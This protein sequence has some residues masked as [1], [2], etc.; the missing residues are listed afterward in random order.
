MCIISRL[1]MCRVFNK[2]LFGPGAK[3][4]VELYHKAT[5]DKKLIGLLMLFGA[6]DRIV[7][8]FK[9]EGEISDGQCIGY[10]EKGVE[11]VRVPLTEPVIIRKEYDEQ[12]DV[13]RFSVT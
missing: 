8:S 5:Q 6:T 11:I 1:Y 2:Q 7:H 9:V 3:K 4:A 13:Q 12:L 10:D